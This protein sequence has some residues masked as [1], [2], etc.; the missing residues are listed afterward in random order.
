M[1]D[2][3]DVW[4]ILPVIED[5]PRYLHCKPSPG[6]QLSWA[7]GYVWVIFGVDKIRRFIY[8]YNYYIY[9]YIILYYIILYYIIYNHVGI[10]IYRILGDFG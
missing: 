2:A 7:R 5:L 9:I 1:R 3:M 8:I 10:M 6:E 4:D